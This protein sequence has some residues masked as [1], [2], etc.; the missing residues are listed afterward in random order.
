MDE[1]DSIIY[2]HNHSLDDEERKLSIQ[3]DG[4]SHK[5]NDRIESEPESPIPC[6]IDASNANEGVDL[7]VF[8][9]EQNKSLDE[10]DEEDLSV[11][12]A[13]L[14]ISSTIPPST[15]HYPRRRSFVHD[16]GRDD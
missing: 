6:Q 10:A 4:V 16:L 14:V 13:D 8:Y 15:Q 2:L 5:Q 1:Q 9:M 7:E 11:D 12:F 3:T